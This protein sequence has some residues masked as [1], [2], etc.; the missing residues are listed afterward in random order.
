MG[1]GPAHLS[2]IRPMSS[3]QTTSAPLMLSV[4]GCRGIV[5]ASLT[6]ETIA[7][8]VAAAVTWTRSAA[9][10]ARPGVVLA[11]DGRAGGECVARLASGALALAGCRVIDLGVATTPTAGVMV[12]HHKAHAG[13]VATASHN[14]A[15]WNGLKVVTNK[16]GAPGPRDAADIVARFN[17]GEHPW[18]PHDR[19]G[20][21]ERDGS[22]ALVHVQRVLDATAELYPLN[23]VRRR[24]FRV[25]LDSVNASGALAGR[26]LLE[27]LGC[28]LFHVN[29]ET[30]GVF[31]HPPEPTRENLASLGEQVR[32]HQADVGFAQDPD[33]DRLA[34][35][36]ERGEYIGE[37]YTL[38]LGVKSW[39]AMLP[40]A[41][42]KAASVAANLSTSRMIDDVA[43]AFGARVVRTAVGEANVVEGMVRNSC[44][45][46]GEGNGG[47][48][49]PEVVPIR[50]SLGAMALTLALL[51]RQ[52]Q[53]LSD[54]ARAI[55][56]Y[57]I[58]KRKIDVREGL[59]ARAVSAVKAA[60]A[61]R[62]AKLNDADGVRADFTCASGAAW[63][64]VRASNTEPIIR[65]IAEAP[66]AGDAHR[67][68]DD[69]QRLVDG[70]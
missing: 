54:A 57:A 23:N 16:G 12:L 14:P 31:P 17:A 9:G 34:M 44:A 30:T 68:L 3:T 53:A 5:G 15:Q 64:H 70:A 4:S 66:D 56:A 33:A 29:A 59:A 35:L 46:G 13:L 24:G 62:G 28:R 63:V 2:I 25:V 50:D 26:M 42:A 58:V 10:A 65:L 1:G 7:R 55:P 8:F 21:V 41:Q 48:I 49:W 47:V 27:A 40:A 20:T 6:P 11:R 22:A 19:L 43:G 18:Q 36:D 60:F 67:A 52:G 38:A 45:L 51:T 61:A 39:L 37:E 32:H 69:V